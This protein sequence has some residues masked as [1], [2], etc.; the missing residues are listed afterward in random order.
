MSEFTYE[1]TSFGYIRIEKGSLSDFFNIQGIDQV[2]VSHLEKKKTEIKKKPFD[3][4]MSDCE[5]ERVLDALPLFLDMKYGKTKITS[6]K[7][8]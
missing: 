2:L 4:V 3:L 8:K 7:I 5:H 1:K 6:G